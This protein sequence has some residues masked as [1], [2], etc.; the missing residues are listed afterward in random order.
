MHYTSLQSGKKI[1]FASDFH[2]GIPD[3]MASRAREKRLCAWLDSIKKDAQQLFLVGDLFDSWIEYKRVVPAGYVR[4]I[5]KLAELAD[6][7][8]EIIIFTGNHDLWM[9]GYFERELGA[10]VYTDAQDF[11]IA[12]KHFHIA[13]GDGVSDLERTYIF[14]KKVFHHPW[15]QWLY[16]KLHPD[17]G[18]A[19]ADYFSRKGVKHRQ[20]EAMT[21]KPNHEEFQVIYAQQKMKEGPVHYFVFGHRHIPIKLSLSEQTWFINLGDWIKFDSYGVFDGVNLDLRFFQSE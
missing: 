4:F 21:M 16:R 9:C 18:L 3:E 11:V 19:I 13:H 5:G 17:W 20:E 1:Y 14:M 7:G 2:L 12:G 6:L 15:S 10:T 8:I